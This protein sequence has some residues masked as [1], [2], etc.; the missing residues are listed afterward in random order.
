VNCQ[1]ETVSRISFPTPIALSAL[2]MCAAC[3]TEDA[4]DLGTDLGAVEGGQSGG[5]TR[6]DNGG[7]LPGDSSGAGKQVSH[8]PDECACLEGRLEDG[9]VPVALIAEIVHWAPPCVELTVTEELA[10]A[11]GI[12][13]GSIIGGEVEPLCPDPDPPGFTEGE[14][15]LAVYHPYYP[16]YSNC[17]AYR[18]C[19]QE[20]CGLELDASGAGVVAG[21][22]DDRCDGQCITDT[23]EQCT[24][25]EELERLGGSVKLAKLDD[26]DVAFHWAGKERTESLTQLSAPECR[27]RLS[28]LWEEQQQPGES[29]PT[30]WSAS[31]PRQETAPAEPPPDD[32]ATTPAPPAGLLCPEASRLSSSTDAGVK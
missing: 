2:T 25:S 32:A 12:E 8:R 14:R 1:G 21:D 4:A 13:V 11:W 6:S 20:V 5:E 10:D 30:A 26:R 3:N 22:D 15:V 18:D 31:S 29:E 7:P 19:T 24:V 28:D 17:Q 9:A 23:Y 27:Q 16:N